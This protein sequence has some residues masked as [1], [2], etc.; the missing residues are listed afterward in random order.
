MWVVK[1]LGLTPGKNP[2]PHWTG[3]L[4]GPG[5]GLSVLDKKKIICTDW[6]SKR[7]QYHDTPAPV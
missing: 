5:D 7:G 4:V 2:C 1:T 6:D 3:G